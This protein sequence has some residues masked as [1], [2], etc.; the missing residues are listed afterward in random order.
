MRASTASSS[1]SAGGVQPRD[2]DHRID[3]V[4]RAVGGDAQVVFLA[5]LAGAER[6]G[7][8]VAGARVDAVEHHHRARALQRPMIQ[9]VSMMTTSATN[10]SS[11][12]QRISF[13]DVCGE[14]PRAKLT[15]PKQQDDRDGAKRERHQGIDEDLGHRD[16]IPLQGRETMRGGR[17]VLMKCV[18]ACQ[19]CTQPAL[20]PCARSADCQPA[21]AGRWP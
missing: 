13:C 8:V 2:A 3:L 9:I 4:E 16:L 6:G 18:T 17:R 15:K 12:R 14:P 11:T 19:C 21:I 5:P 10:C 20:K 1:L 7:A